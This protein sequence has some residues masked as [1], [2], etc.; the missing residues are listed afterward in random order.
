MCLCFNL[1]GL[2]EDHAPV[3]G[4]QPR[5]VWRKYNLKKNISFK[6]LFGRNADAFFCRKRF[7]TFV[8]TPREEA[9]LG[10]ADKN[11]TC[12]IRPATLLSF[13]MINV[14]CKFDLSVY[15]AK[16]RKDKNWNE[17]SW[18]NTFEWL[19]YSLQYK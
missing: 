10:F 14:L 15:F 5:S 11:K 2:L 7:C 9:F 12:I 13:L 6:T 1:C 8:V 3:F 16:P 18:R 4:H 17:A 19:S